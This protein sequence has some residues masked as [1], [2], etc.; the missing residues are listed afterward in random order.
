MLWIGLRRLFVWGCDLI[1]VWVPKLWVICRWDNDYTHLLSGMS[2][3]FVI[4]HPYVSYRFLLELCMNSMKFKLNAIIDYIVTWYP[5]FYRWN[6]KEKSYSLAPFYPL[7]DFAVYYWRIPTRSMDTQYEKNGYDVWKS[8]EVWRGCTT[9]WWNW[10][11]NLTH[12]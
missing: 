7:L 3:A 11:C 8:V 4:M 5:C 2:I 1:R 9:C 12:L 10:V 6:V